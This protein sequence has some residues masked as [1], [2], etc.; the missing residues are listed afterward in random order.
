MRGVVLAISAALLLS[1]CMAR[2]WTEHAYPAWGFAVSYPGAVVEEPGGPPAE[3]RPPLLFAVDGAGEDSD[4]SVAIVD[5]ASADVSDEEAINQAV[6]RI[7]HGRDTHIAYWATGDRGQHMGRAAVIEEG[8]G[9]KQSLHLVVYNHRLY[10][11]SGRSMGAQS[12][13]VAKFLDSFRLIEA[14]AAP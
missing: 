6:Q 5:L 14:P 13:K 12:P 1:G 11:V 7:A 8:A 2:P 10:E 4:L 9:L 3:G